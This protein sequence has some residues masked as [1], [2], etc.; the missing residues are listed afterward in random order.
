MNFDQ[1]FH[2][3][4]QYVD[5]VGLLPEV[6][7][8][9]EEEAKSSI[10]E[11]EGLELELFM[12]M[13]PESFAAKAMNPKKRKPEPE[14]DGEGI[15]RHPTVPCQQVHQHPRNHQLWAWKHQVKHTVYRHQDSSNLLVHD[16]HILQSQLEKGQMWNVKKR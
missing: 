2:C 6:S 9:E 15:T 10:W 16:Q 7:T 1:R 13:D 12:A 3:Y 14:T 5:I 8:R 4:D 11:L